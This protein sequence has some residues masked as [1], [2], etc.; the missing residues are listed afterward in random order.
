M[1]GELYTFKDEGVGLFWRLHGGHS[2]TQVVQCMSQNTCTSHYSMSD[3]AG[4][5][6]TLST[7]PL[8]LHADIL[9]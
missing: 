5:T 1:G 4:V 9:K 6:T 2:S 3:L 7:E 8:K